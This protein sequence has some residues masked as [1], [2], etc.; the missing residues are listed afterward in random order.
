MKM[1]YNLLPVRDRE[2]NVSAGITFKS[3]GLGY[4][5]KLKCA[6]HQYFSNFHMHEIHLG[7]L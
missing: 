4:M 6:V 7:V 2:R 5:N 3:T 1:I